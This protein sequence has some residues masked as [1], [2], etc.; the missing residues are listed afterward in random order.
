MVR[1]VRLELLDCRNV[2]HAALDLSPSFNFLHGSNGAGKTA[3]LE[4][5]HVLARGRSFRS[6]QLQDVIRVGCDRMV[7]RAT[8]LDEHLGGQ[9]LVFVRLRDSTT[10]MR[11][12]G[13]P[14]ARMSQVSALLPL[15]VMTPDLVEL[16]FGGP[17]VRRQWLDW[18]VFHV[19]HEFLGVTRRFNQSLRQRNACLKAVA[20]GRLAESALDSWDAELSKLGESLAEL[21][22]DHFDGLEGLIVGCLEELGADFEARMNYKCGWD[23]DCKLPEALS[24]ARAK[25]LRLGVTSAGPHR[26]DVEFITRGQPSAVTLSRGQAKVL[27]SALLLAQAD[28]IRACASRIG[29]FL[30][31]DIG[32]ELDGRHRRL[33]FRALVSR[34]VQV[35]ATSV[36]RPELPVLEECGESATFHVEQGRINRDAVE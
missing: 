4:A 10:E 35:L 16:V 12:N 6:N 21:R 29:L 31:D 28:H 26:A 5:V 30:I 17:G 22:R 1:V 8:V 36:D 15:E 33:F 23:D 3:V 7:V 9:R 13:E 14:C 20:A 34:G 18:G 24:R 11:I 27:A 2:E 25:D 19:K 32:A